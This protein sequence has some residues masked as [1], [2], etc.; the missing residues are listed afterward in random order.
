[1]GGDGTG[2]AKH[3][4]R[5]TGGDRASPPNQGDPMKLT[6]SIVLALSM[7]IPAVATLAH[8]DDKA[9]PAGDKTAEGKEAAPAKAKKG[10]VKKEEKKD[11]AGAEKAPAA[12]KA[13]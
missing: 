11:E 2:A 10:K 5:Q 3:P 8:A 12:E 13:K 9:P 6:R 4:A 7:T 1:M